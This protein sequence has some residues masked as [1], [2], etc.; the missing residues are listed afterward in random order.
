[1]LGEALPE[2]R[3]DVWI[4]AQYERM[5]ADILPQGALR[6][7]TLRAEE[8]ARPEMA[9][10]LALD[11]A[12]AL[13]TRPCANPR[14]LKIVGCREREARGKLCSGCMVSRYCYRECQVAGWLA[15]KGVCG[16]LGAEREASA[17]EA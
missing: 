14:C 17:A 2:R 11:E 7:R 15:H 13:A 5:A 1:M 16:A 8:A 9:P 4:V 10:A 6:L 12:R 3:E